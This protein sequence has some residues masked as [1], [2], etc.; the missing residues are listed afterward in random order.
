MGEMKETEWEIWINKVIVKGTSRHHASNSK[1][2]KVKNIKE[3]VLYIFL[4]TNFIKQ[5]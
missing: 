5:N 1:C 2:F 4:L 3:K